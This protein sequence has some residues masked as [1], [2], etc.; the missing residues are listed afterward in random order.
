MKIKELLYIF[1]L[2][3]AVSSCNES[4]NRNSLDKSTVIM[5]YKNFSQSIVESSNNRDGFGPTLRMKQNLADSSQIMNK[6]K[7]Y[8]FLVRSSGSFIINRSIEYP[9]VE[10]TSIETYEHISRQYDGSYVD[11]TELFIKINN[12]HLIK[13]RI[14]CPYLNSYARDLLYYFNANMKATKG[15]YEFGD[16]IDAIKSN[17]VKIYI[18]SADINV[19]YNITKDEEGFVGY[20]WLDKIS[21]KYDFA[22]DLYSGFFIEISS[23]KSNDEV[24]KYFNI[25][26]DLISYS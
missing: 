12:T 15:Y 25:I 6:L 10:N 7:N 13:V 23:N 5:D 9:Y 8:Y 20:I 19:K 17:N 14:Y 11:L 16:A 18:N 1:L 21:S 3:S 26:K 2:F 4:I 22:S 24:L